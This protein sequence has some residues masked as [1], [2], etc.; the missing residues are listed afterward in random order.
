MIRDVFLARQPIFDM[1]Q[2]V[3]G[4]EIL[5]RNGRVGYFDGVD[6][7]MAS[8]HVIINTFQS[9]G[10]ENLTN[11]KPAFVNFTDNLINEGVAT[12]FPKDVLVVEVLETVVVDEDIIENCRL[13]KEKGY[14]I[15]LDDF[16]YDEERLALIE[17][18]DII[19]IDF[20][21]SSIG[22]IK[23]TISKLKSM[24]LIWLAEK[25]ETREEF[26]EAKKL[27]F[28]LFQGFFFSKPETLTT[29][30]LQ[31]IKLNYIGLINKF[32]DDEIDFEEI[33]EIVSRDISMTYSILKLINSPAFDLRRIIKSV[34]EAVVIL[35][36]R[37]IR[38]WLILL[39]LNGL[40]SDKPDEIVRL[41]LI[42]AKFGETI[43]AK[44]LRYED[45]KEDLFLAGLFSLLD[46]ILEKS[47]EDI[48]K[49][50]KIS[51]DIKNCLLGRGSDLDYILKLIFEYEKANWEG[52]KIYSNLLKIDNQDVMDAYIQTLLWYDKFME[53]Y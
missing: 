23:Y 52:V 34:R 21:K 18:A 49:E 5:F 42:R 30:S 3:Y 45:R 51:Q 35:G 12:L 48:L 33:A 38:K 9:F 39:A 7:D 28:S 24:G 11:K 26:E 1:K 14:I 15:A 44:T 46:V 8:S 40:G 17:L 4:Y 37:E 20:M 13:L 43:A 53:G 2:N 41:S 36:E 50:I 29:S 6:G 31:P 25:V 16:I 10:I 22:E 47:L 27:G 19:K 32:N